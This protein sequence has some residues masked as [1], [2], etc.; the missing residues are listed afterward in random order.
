MTDPTRVVPVAEREVP[1]AA[2]QSGDSS[3]PAKPKARSVGLDVLRFVAVTLVLYSHVTNFESTRIFFF[4]PT[5][6]WESFRTLREA[7]WIGVD[8]F[9]VLSGFLVSG[10][11]F[12]E[13]SARGTVS[14]GRFLIRRGFKI[15]PAFW[16]MILVTVVG[17]WLH[18]AGISLK[19][20]CSELF[21]FQNYYLPAAG[22]AGFWGHTWTL[23]VEEH[24]YF[25]LAGLFLFLKRRADAGA[26][27]NVHIIPK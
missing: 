4:R 21:Y 20:L 2:S 5:W 24:F 27:F 19:T 17:L 14:P 25:L 23:A 15:Y 1:S 12:E 26:P 3:A 11:L 7:G 6:L 9:F 8:I 22:P 16:A 10:L 18:G 13:L